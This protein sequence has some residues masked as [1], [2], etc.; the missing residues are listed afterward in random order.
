MGN[1]PPNINQE[2]WSSIANAARRVAQNPTV[3]KGVKSATPF[4]KKYMPYATAK[5]FGLWTIGPPALFMAWRAGQVLFG[6]APRKCGVFTM[7]A[8]SP[9]RDICIARFRIQGLTKQ[10]QSLKQLLSIARTKGSTKEQIQS[11]E[12]KIASTESKLAHYNMKIKQTLG[13]QAAQSQKQ[14]QNTQQMASREQKEEVVQEIIPFILPVIGTAF[15]IFVGVAIDAVTFRM[16]RT[17][18]A[19][20][21][22]ATRR[23]GIYKRDEEH[24]LCISKV[25]LAISQKQ[26]VILQKAMTQCPHNRNPVKCKQKLDEEIIKLREKIQLYSDNIV[27]LQNQIQ[28]KKAAGAMK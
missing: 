27:G 23:C 17:L 1:K 3:Q 7:G 18:K 5:S 9:G 6:L 8:G 24:D 2:Q 21:D 14:Y 4:V 22:Q 25:R 13:K 12:Q 16:W 20:F 10:L 19:A 28:Q 15:S 11:L 26:M